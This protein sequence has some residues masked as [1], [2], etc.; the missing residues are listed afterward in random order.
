[1]AYVLQRRRGADEPVDLGVASG[2]DILSLVT[3]LFEKLF[4]RPEPR[5]F[6]AD[7]PVGDASRELNQMS[8]QV[9][10]FY[11]LTHVQQEY[12]S[13]ITLSSALKHQADGLRNGHEIAS[14]VGVCDLYGS[15]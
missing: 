6:D 12:F 14:D 7:V 4:T 10:N 5:E 3:E 1:M 8:S 9:E 13:A 15:A 11:G 2:N